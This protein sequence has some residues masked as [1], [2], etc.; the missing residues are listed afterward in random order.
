MG[1]DINGNMM[2]RR[3]VRV[4]WTEYFDRLL[5]VVDDK[6]ARISIVVRVNVQVTTG[7]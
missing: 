6:E 4:K 2:K 5:N 7:E 3:A 1:K